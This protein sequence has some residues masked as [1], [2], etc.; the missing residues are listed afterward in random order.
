MT[1]SARLS[2]AIFVLDQIGAGQSVEAALTQW[3]RASRYAGSGDRRAVRDLVFDALRAKRSFAALGGRAVGAADTGRSLVLGGLR[4]AQMPDNDIAALFSGENHAPAPLGPDDIARAPLPSESLDLPDWLIP[5]LQ[6]SPCD[7]PAYAQALKSRAP[8]FLRVNLAKISAD[9]LGQKLAALGIGFAAVP[10]LPE[11]LMLTENAARL[12]ASDIIAQG[13]AELQDASS[14]A[15]V[16][17]LDLPQTG[18]IMD[19][20]A[21]GGGKILAI[22][23]RLPLAKGVTLHAHDA[24]PQRMD[25]LPARAARAQA[26]VQITPNLPEPKSFDRHHQGYDLI[27]CDVPCSGSGSWRRD[28]M[29]K[30]VLSPQKLAQVQ[31]LQASILDRAAMYLAPGGQLAYSTCSVLYSENEAQIAAFLQRQPHFS[32]VFM[33]RFGLGNLRP[34]SQPK[35]DSLGDGFF[36]AVLRE[37]AT[38]D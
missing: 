31:A 26:N 13:W 25:D 27:L 16:A 17:A 30:W 21:G 8:L 34:Q 33:Q 6:R 5:E 38:S 37:G 20:C 14:Q 10:P 35:D 32:C 3:G 28:P 23:A 2:A 24:N 18:R 1:P 9:A 7:L 19:F 11:T 4:A 29:G 36:L 22:A 15:V 12:A